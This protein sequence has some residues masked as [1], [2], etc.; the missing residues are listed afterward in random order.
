MSVQMDFIVVLWVGD[1]IVQMDFIV[2]LWVGDMNVQMDF[3][4]V[5]WVGDRISLSCKYCTVWSLEFSSHKRVRRR[6]VDNAGRFFLSWQLS[7]SVHSPHR[8]TD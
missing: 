2:V 1:M 6:L 5:L 3:I 7:P 4:V 8:V